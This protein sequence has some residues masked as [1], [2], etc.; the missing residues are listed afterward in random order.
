MNLKDLQYFVS[1]AEQKHFGKAAEYCHVSQPTLSMQLKKLEHEIDTL[2]FEREH[3]QVMLTAAGEA[4]L[5]QAKSII[6]SSEQFKITAKAL[7]DPFGG[8]IRLGAIPT[9][10][11]YL[12]PKIVPNITKKLPNLT[13]LLEEHQTADLLDLLLSGRLD[14]GIL[15]LPIPHK[16]VVSLPL[17]K[18]NF[19]LAAP[20]KHALAKATHVKIQALDETPLLLLEEGHCLR[21]QTL[22]FCNMIRINERRDF[23]A[24]SLETLRQMVL[25]NA[26]L[27]IIPEMALDKHPGIRYLPFIEPAPYREIVLICRDAYPRFDLIKSLQQLIITKLPVAS[28]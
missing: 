14:A 9:I 3:K 16:H 12:F 10:A 17:L 5:P 26:G 15:A 6:Q 27:T 23:R 24:T 2:L 7:K 4:L 11:P 28:I 20:I 21:D 8:E 13:L 19:Y 1:V 18:E 22:N 25:S